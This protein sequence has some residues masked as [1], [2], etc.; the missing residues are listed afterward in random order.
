[1]ENVNVENERL[2]RRY[3]SFLR[4][5]RGKD[6]KTVDK[7]AAALAAFE[8]STRWKPFGKYHIE[9]AKAFTST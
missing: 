3:F 5:S 6:E 9:Q 8:R 7:V 4:D 1:M 2:K